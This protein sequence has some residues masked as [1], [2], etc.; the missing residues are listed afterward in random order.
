MGVYLNSRKPHSIFQDEAEATYFVDKTSVLD[1]LIPLL[2]GEDGSK[3]NKY[4][5]ITRPRRFGKTVMASMIASFFGKG[6][7]SSDLFRNLRIAAS[8]KFENHIN[9]HDVIYIAFNEIPDECTT[10]AQYIK[11]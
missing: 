6:E 8:E 1:E 4:I 10:Y 11:D 5:C 2:K 9:K 7:N 3:G